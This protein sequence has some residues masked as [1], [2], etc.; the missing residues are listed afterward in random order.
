[1]VCDGNLNIWYLNSGC[2]GTCIRDGGG[3]F[4]VP[5]LELIKEWAVKSTKNIFNE[6]P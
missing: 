4:I 6:Y 2:V 5:R 3:P 1:M